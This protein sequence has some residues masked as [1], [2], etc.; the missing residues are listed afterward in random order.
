MQRSFDLFTEE[1]RVCYKYVKAYCADPEVKKVVL[2]AHSQGCIMAS[3][4]L[5][6]LYLDLLVEAVAK[7]EVNYC[8]KSKANIMLTVNRFTP[9]AML[10]LTSTIRCVSF[11]EHQARSM[12]ETCHQFRMETQASPPLVVRRR[13]K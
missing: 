11:L 10:P 4:I 13:H 12:H 3:Q 2:I 5:D 6:Q 8:P 9:S 1:T 7:L